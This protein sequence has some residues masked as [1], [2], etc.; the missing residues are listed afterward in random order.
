MLWPDAMK[1][2]RIPGQVNGSVTRTYDAN[3][4]VAVDTPDQGITETQPVRLVVRV[5]GG[6]NP[7]ITP[8]ELSGVRAPLH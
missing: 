2:A 3:F 5:E 7:G 4:S 1:S 6:A 8:P